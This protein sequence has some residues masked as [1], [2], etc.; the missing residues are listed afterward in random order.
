MSLDA[1]LAGWLQNNGFA[2]G[3]V[4][5]RGANKI[6]PL[7]QAALTGD[8]EIA[9]QLIAAGADVA[10][11]NADGNNAIWLACVEQRLDMIDILA[12]AGVDLDHQNDGGASALMFCASSGRFAAVRHLV[13]RGAKIA[14]ETQ[15]GFSA[16]DMANTLEI[17]NYLR[18]TRRAQRAAS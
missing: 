10:L 14:A 9:R 6:T 8:A 12:Q 1:E 5:G 4:N 16:I 3:D 17:L 13:E 18:A 15:D 11:T 2:G 7:M